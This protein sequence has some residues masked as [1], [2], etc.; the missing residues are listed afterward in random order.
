MRKY[1]AIALHVLIGLGFGI[2]SKFKPKLSYFK[3]GIKKL[4]FIPFFIQPSIII[5]LTIT[6]L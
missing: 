3:E 6:L 1:L 4:S 2:L 5:L